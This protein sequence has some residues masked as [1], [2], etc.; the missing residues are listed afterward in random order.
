M[1]V[2][3][4]VVSGEGLAAELGEAVVAGLLGAGLAGGLPTI[5]PRVVPRGL[6]TGAS[7]VEAFA[8]LSDTVPRSLGRIGRYCACGGIQASAS[9]LAAAAMTRKLVARW[10]GR[11][12]VRVQ[13][14]RTRR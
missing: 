1:A 9:K 8:K 2:P 6:T 11:P 3:A 12:R 14:S 7:T 10:N 5:L 4:G 13:A